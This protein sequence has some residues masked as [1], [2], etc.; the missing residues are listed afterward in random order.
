MKAAEA[1]M[2]HSRLH[3]SFNATEPL[4]EP[5]FM[6]KALKL[7]IPMVMHFTPHTQLFALIFVN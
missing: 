2:K 7:S 6:N 5:T 1:E 3:S 4:Y